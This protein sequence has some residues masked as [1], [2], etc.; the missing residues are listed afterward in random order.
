V[1]QDSKAQPAA[2]AAGALA[3]R[4]AEMTLTKAGPVDTRVGNPRNIRHGTS[5][6][7]R[8]ADGFQPLGK[9]CAGELRAPIGVE[10]CLAVAFAGLFKGVETERGVVP[11]SNRGRSTDPRP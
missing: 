1:R 7:V 3:G 9:G 5:Y 11:G 2:V 4:L 6:I 8:A 10:K